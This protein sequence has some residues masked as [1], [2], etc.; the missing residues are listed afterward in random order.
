MK[1]FLYPIFVFAFIVSCSVVQPLISQET[2]WTK[3]ADFPFAAGAEVPVNS[4]FV[5]SNGNYFAGIGTGAGLY[6]SLDSGKTW[7][8]S[9]G[10]SWYSHCFSF[11]ITPKGTIIAAMTRNV[12]SVDSCWLLASSDNGVNYSKLNFP[13]VKIT[14][15]YNGPNGNQYVTTDSGIYR[16]NDNGISW[17]LISQRLIKGSVKSVVIYNNSLYAAVDGEGIF[18]S[19]DISSNDDNLSWS[20]IDAG[21]EFQHTNALNI[22]HDNTLAATNQY[23]VY[24]Y[25]GTSEWTSIFGNGRTQISAET[26]FEHNGALYIGLN[27][28]SAYISKDNAK[29]WALLFSGFKSTIVNDFAIDSNGVILA[30]TNTGVFKGNTNVGLLALETNLVEF[31]DTEVGSQSEKTIAISNAGKAP[32]MITSAQTNGQQSADFS[33]KNIALPV[34]LQPG[35]S[36]DI[37]IAFTPSSTGARQST[38][39]LST[40]GNASSSTNIEI[41]GKGLQTLSVDETDAQLSI[42]N[43]NG[44]LRVQSPSAV[45][46][47][48]LH[49]LIGNQQIGRMQQDGNTTILEWNNLSNGVY[50]LH[51]TT[52]QTSTTLPIIINR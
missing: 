11:C 15:L 18:R 25:S 52:S 9:N 51:C 22:I 37:T 1:Q 5:N 43:D 13:N 32:L 16:S 44:T 46:N 42:V 7:L 30:A 23:G 20:D 38:L 2:F 50:V 40:S 26:L 33:V 27:G 45:K 19:G 47:A 10:S 17:Q 34:A 39:Q 36:I 3:T 14:K 35:K 8:Q 28:G 24:Y 48:T 12:N 41:L 31:N 21:V 49:S 6:R 4:I 29:T